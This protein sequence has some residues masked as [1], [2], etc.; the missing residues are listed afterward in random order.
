MGAAVSEHCGACRNPLVEDIDLR[1]PVAPELER[2][3]RE[4]HGLARAGW[5]NDQHVPDVADMSRE[6]ER[7]R[8]CGLRHQQGRSSEMVV[9]GRACP[10]A[11]QWHEMR[12]EEHTSELQ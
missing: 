8:S 7:R 1:L 10:N 9:A 4:Q 5:A 2:E 6:P 12:S 3:G 11:R